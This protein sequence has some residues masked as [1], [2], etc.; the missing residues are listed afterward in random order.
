MTTILL[1]NKG[2]L[3]KY[4][5]DAIV[6]FFGAPVPV[7]NH[8]LYACQ[9]ALEM[10][11]GLEKLRRRWKSEGDQWPEIVH[12]MQNRIGIHTGT[13]VTGNMGSEQRMNYT[14]MGDTVNLA[15]RLESSCKQ[16]GVYTQISESTYSAVKDD[17]TVRELDRI[18]VLGRKEP[19]TTYELVSL[20]GKETESMKELLQGF[21]EAIQ[22]YRGM[23]WDKAKKLFQSLE[24]HETMHHGRST[25]PCRVYIQRCDAYK[26]SPPQEPWDGVTVLTSK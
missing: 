21:G 25:N 20:K 12:N 18:V 16:Y 22:L 8:E 17:V 19:V 6:A 24:K 13:M 23:E 5:G 2:T 3:D 14:M 10:Q 15:A 26:K 11:D 4:I 1:E 7:E 9:A